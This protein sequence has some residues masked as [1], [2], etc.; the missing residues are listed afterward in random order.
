MPRLDS[1]GKVLEDEDDE[2]RPICYFTLWEPAAI[3]GQTWT[4][5]G[6]DVAVPCRK[7]SKKRPPWGGTLARLLYPD[8]FGRCQAKRL[9]HARDGSLGLA[10][11]GA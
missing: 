1:T 10:S 6:P 11:A 7:S 8:G 9:Q 5:G 4:V 3:D 2:G